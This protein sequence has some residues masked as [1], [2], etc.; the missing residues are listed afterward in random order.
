MGLDQYPTR[1][2]SKIYNESGDSRVP[3]DI[4]E[5]MD[6][7]KGD[8]LNWVSDSDEDF[9]RVYGPEEKHNED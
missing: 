3:A 2:S 6:W 8:E 9:V 1:A 5:D 7:D 4:A